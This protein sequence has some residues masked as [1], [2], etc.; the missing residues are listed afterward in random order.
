[1]RALPT[2]ARYG[3]WTSYTNQS[4]KSAKSLPYWKDSF[5]I[6]RRFG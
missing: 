3:Q 6:Y 1:M 5:T 2:K 4:R